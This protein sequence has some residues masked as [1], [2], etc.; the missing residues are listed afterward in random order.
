MEINKLTLKDRRFPKQLKN[1]AS[2]PKELYV[3]GDLTPLLAKSRIAI[4]GSRKVSVYGRRITAELARELAKRG[5][6]II[7]GL[8]LGVDAIAH[9]AALE[10]GGL[11]IAVLPRGLDKIYPASHHQLA[12]Q[13]T[14][15][16][17]ALVSEYPANT[18]IYRTNFIARNRLIAGLSQAT[19][20]TEAAEKSGSLHTA[21]FTLEQGKDVLA[22]PGNITSSTSVGTN[23]LLKAGATPVTSYLDVLHALGLKDEKGTQTK[24]TFMGNNESEQK[25]LELL[26]SGVSDGD[27]LLKRSDLEIALFN[28]TL[29]MLEISGHIRALGANHWDVS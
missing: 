12:K 1:I 29:T 15:H 16:G 20:I 26:R 13:I 22:V 9:Q 19:L 11:T 4:V 24:T 28:Q 14:K 23:N 27:T 18:E 3:D 7:S 6:V 25:L 10:V 2:A 5:I 17:G 21:R 8:A